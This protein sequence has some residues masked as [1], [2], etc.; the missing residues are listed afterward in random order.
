M[1]LYDAAGHPRMVYGSRPGELAGA[2]DSKSPAPAHS[3]PGS[4]HTCNLSRPAE[5]R[6]THRSAAQ[7]TK[8]EEGEAASVREEPATDGS[9]IKTVLFKNFL[10][11]GIYPSMTGPRKTQRLVLG[12]AADKQVWVTGFRAEVLDDKNNAASQQFM[13]HSGRRGSRRSGPGELSRA[14]VHRV[15]VTG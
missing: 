11:D 3:S 1:T 15:P 6:E 4:E 12:S 13:C 8:K 7:G 14:G 5:L 2:S 10:I 9:R